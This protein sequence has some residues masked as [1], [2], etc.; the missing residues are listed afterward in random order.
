[1][2]LFENK[3]SND[4]LQELGGS[5]FEIVDGQPDINGWD[6]TDV[7]GTYIGEVEELIFDTVTRKVLYLIVDLEGNDLDLDSRKV[8]VPIGLA[9]LHEKEDEVIL[10]EL[11]SQY[12]SSL[13]AYE[14]GK[15]SPGT[16]S[17][18]RNTFTGLAAAIA[19]GAT[20][21]QADSENINS[22]D[23]YNH[24]HFDQ[25]RFYGACNTSS[26]PD[27]SIPII[28]ENLSV[29]S[30]SIITGGE[31]ITT[32]VIETPVEESISLKEEH[33][34]IDRQPTDKP[35]TESD[36]Q[37]FKEGEMKLTEYKEIPVV[38]KQA[39]IVEEVN[40]YKTVT[41]SEK[42]IKDTVRRTEVDTEF[43]DPD[44]K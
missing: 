37:T 2:A 21:Y 9:T 20:S 3:N 6:V 36:F 19:S 15:I 38:S 22:D 34:H 13:P 5:D 43:L 30:E 32:K 1:M 10:A 4:R 25:N 35:A 7:S 31:R 23:F 12:L 17:T 24:E 16:E 42:I 26:V 8:L 28:E 40:V 29:N 27:S 14:K 41:E 11:T 44:T 33:I 39:K 18:I